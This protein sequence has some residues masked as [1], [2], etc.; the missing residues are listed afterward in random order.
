MH[1]ELR[2]TEPELLAQT[3]ETDIPYCMVSCSAIKAGVKREKWENV[4]SDDICLPKKLL[5]VMSPDYL[6]V[7]EHLPAQGIQ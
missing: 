6:G 7:A 2:G 3:G 1:E 4:Q 5:G